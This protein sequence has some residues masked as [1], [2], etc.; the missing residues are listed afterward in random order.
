MC[1]TLQVFQSYEGAPGAIV[2]SKQPL[3]IFTGDA[4]LSS[5]F[6]GCLECAVKSA[7]LVTQHLNGDV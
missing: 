7:Q 2:V 5:T 1:V 3:L 4:F 6:D